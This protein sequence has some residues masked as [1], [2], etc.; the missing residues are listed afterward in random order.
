LKAETGIKL[1][2]G[3]Q[4][5]A[6]STKAHMIHSKHRSQGND[7]VRKIGTRMQTQ[8]A[9]ICKALVGVEVVVAG[10]P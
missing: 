2:C 7:R 1:V 9:R 6:G 8:G 10:R 3:A 5:G 4:L